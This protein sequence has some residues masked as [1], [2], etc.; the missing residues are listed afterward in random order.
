[1]GYY[2]TFV[3]KLWCDDQGKMM[4]GHV[5]HVSS[6]EASHFLNL[7]D[8]TDFISSCIGDSPGKADN[9]DEMAGGPQLS[10]ESSV[11]FEQDE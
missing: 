1:L 6:L 3:V 5:Q 11:C 4:R 10:S 8:M 9:P 7:S 2:S